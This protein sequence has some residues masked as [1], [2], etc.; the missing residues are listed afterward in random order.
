MYTPVLKKEDYMERIAAMARMVG[1]K[2]LDAVL[3]F[4]NEAEPANVRYFTNYRPIFESTAIVISRSG[5]AV[6]LIGPETDELVKEH[7][8]LP[9]YKKLLEFRESSDPDYPD[10]KIDTFED[11]FTDLNGGKKVTRLG[12]IG[13]NIMTVQV[14]EGVLRAFPAANLT[15]E[16]DLLRE[17]RMIKSSKELEIL[18]QAA[19]IAGKG[20]E[21]ALERIHPGMTELQAV[22]HCIAGV[23]QNGAEGTGFPVWCLSGKGTNQAIGI[24]T[25]KVI[26]KNEVVQISMGVMLEGYVSS[27]G[28]PFVFGEIS[29]D[30]RRMM[31]VALESNALTHKLLKPGVNASEVASKVHGLVRERGL[32]ECIVYGP[33]HGIGMMECEFPFIETT[34]DIDLQCGMTFAADTYLAGE[35]FGMRFED[36]VAITVDGEEQYCDYRREIIQI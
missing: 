34:S 32:G 35:N 22:A 23:Y 14:Y 11:V 27:F 12:L 4:A 9:D 24:P 25:Q 5:E 30:I 36:T 20:F 6:L 1:E 17:L 13:T 26:E 16:D 2:D 18:K 3:I 7:S 29:D 31:D 10:I 8:V 33:A 28:R 21:Y 15:K 19:E